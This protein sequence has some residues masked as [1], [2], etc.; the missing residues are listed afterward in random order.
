M[1]IVCELVDNCE[2]C[3]ACDGIPSP[4]LAVVLTESS[5]EACKDH[6]YVCN[7]GNQDIG[8]RKSSKKSKIQKYEW[9]RNR[10]VDVS[11]P[12][13]LTED[14]LFCVWDFLVVGL[15]NDNLLEGD[16][17]TGGDGEVRQESNGGNEGCQDVEQAFLLQLVS[18]LNS[19][20]GRVC[21]AYN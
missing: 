20:N 1:A 11:C 2:V 21:A 3:N 5:K 16:T 10:P 15:G 7:D 19:R 14:D 17:V 18:G 9:R 13:D 4:L 12:V 8:T 6:D